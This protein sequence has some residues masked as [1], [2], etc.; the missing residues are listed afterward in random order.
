MHSIGMNSALAIPFT[1]DPSA[2]TVTRQRPGTPALDTAHAFASSIKARGA[3]TRAPRW[4]C[5]SVTNPRLSAPN[6]GCSAIIPLSARLANISRPTSL[7]LTAAS[8]MVGWTRPAAWL[9]SSSDASTSPNLRTKRGLSTW[10]PSPEAPSWESGRSFAD[11]PMTDTT[12]CAPI[13]SASSM[14]SKSARVNETPWY[15][16]ETCVT[17]R[18]ASTSS[19]ARTSTRYR[20]VPA[21]RSAG[22][23]VQRTPSFVAD[24][25]RTSSRGRTSSRTP[26]ARRKPLH[27]YVAFRARIHGDNRIRPTNGTSEKMRGRME[28]S[29]SAGS[30]FRAR[31]AFTE[32]IPACDRMKATRSRARCACSSGMRRAATSASAPRLAL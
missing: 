10:M 8:A 24:R 14:S 21:G 19:L 11:A 25:P 6:T 15:A 18:D 3:A 9:G 26:S 22:S 7:R 13:T 2:R 20:A 31:K 12:T 1:G 17:S 16:L 30:D 27:A 4:L 29:Q 28:P 5:L 32:G 23:V